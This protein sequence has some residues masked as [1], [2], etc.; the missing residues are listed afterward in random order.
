MRASCRLFFAWIFDT[1]LPLVFFASSV[2]PWNISVLERDHW[3]PLPRAGLQSLTVTLEGSTL[4][5][6]GQ[7]VTSGD[8]A[9]VT[10]PWVVLTS[11]WVV[12]GEAGSSESDCTACCEALGDVLSSS[13][14]GQGRRG[15]SQSQLGQF[16]LFNSEKT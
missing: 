7:T 1:F 8:R 13:L 4:L 10:I 12:W 11:S 16:A 3:P 14:K 6:E 2:F 15:A 9:L 5:A